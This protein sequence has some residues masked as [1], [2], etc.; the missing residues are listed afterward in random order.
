M[1]DLMDRL[2]EQMPSPQPPERLVERLLLAVR[3]RREA[4]KSLFFW[5]G[6]RSQH[7]AAGLALAGLTLLVMFILE[8]G[9][10]A[11]GNNLGTATLV[12]LDRLLN[13]PQT[14]LADL[15]TWWSSFSS[16]AATAL[17]LALA[18]LALAAFLQA[19]SLLSSWIETPV[20][21]QVQKGRV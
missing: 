3:A 19:S 7:L 15:A 14:A 2:L 6:A 1:T 8:V 21:L 9:E 18:L 12:W 20:Q 16:L 17:P 5:V 11:M 4:E 13:T 10:T